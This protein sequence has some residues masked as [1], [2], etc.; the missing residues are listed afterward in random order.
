MEIDVNNLPELLSSILTEASPNERV[1]S[2]YLDTS[3]DQVSDTAYLLE[4]RDLAKSLRERLPE[5]ER[6]PF[7]ATREQAEAYLHSEVTFRWP[8]LALFATGSST[9][10]HVAALPT[11][12]IGEMVWDSLPIVQPLVR[13]IE[14]TARTCVALFDAREARLLTFRLGRIEERRSLRDDVA[15]KQRGGG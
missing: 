3:P 12:P 13:A 4:F 5:N 9:Y 6:K 1:L 2:V 11:P 8:G 7:E 10:F 15:G 14:E